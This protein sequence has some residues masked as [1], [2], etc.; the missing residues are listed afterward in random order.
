M[1]FLYKASLLLFT[2]HL[3]L[4][5]TGH[6][7]AQYLIFRNIQHSAIVRDELLK[8]IIMLVSQKVSLSI[9]LLKASFLTLGKISNIM[10][11]FPNA[12]LE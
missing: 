6:L 10:F 7:K 12:I 4:M 8:V 2:T 1:Q 3:I 11:P 5:L 9:F